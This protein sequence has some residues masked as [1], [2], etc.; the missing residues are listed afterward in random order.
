MNIVL[1]RLYNPGLTH[2]GDVFQAQSYW[3][4]LKDKFTVQ[5]R[6]LEERAHFDLAKLEKTAQY[7]YEHGAVYQ[8]VRVKDRDKLP[9]AVLVLPDRPATTGESLPSKT[10][11]IIEEAL[12]PVTALW[13]ASLRVS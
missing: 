1:E 2:P 4:G 9:W 3:D 12:D 7:L 8:V 10:A 6:L 13:K 5:H 11:T